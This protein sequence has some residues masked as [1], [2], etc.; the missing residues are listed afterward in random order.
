MYKKDGLFLVIFDYLFKLNC[1]VV[2]ECVQ[3]DTNTLKF[4]N[5]N[6]IANMWS[7]FI[8][9]HTCLNIIYIVQ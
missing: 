8:N 4:E 5:I 3:C 9:A 2:R 1:I 6:F 7:G